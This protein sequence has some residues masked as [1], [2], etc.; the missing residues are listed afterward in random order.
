M[1]TLSTKKFN[2][3]QANKERQLSYVVAKCV[4]EMNDTLEVYH[5][6]MNNIKRAIKKNDFLLAEEMT[7]NYTQR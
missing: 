6:V 1:K 3:A 4:N 2:K 7:K 5:F